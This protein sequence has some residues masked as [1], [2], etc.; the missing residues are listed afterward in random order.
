MDP[1]D[2]MV[3]TIIICFKGNDRSVF[4]F[5]KSINAIAN[6][7]HLDDSKG[8]AVF[9]IKDVSFLWRLKYCKLLT[10]KYAITLES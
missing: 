8:H 7:Y 10:D 5:Q 4:K 2:L 9:G 6:L 1:I 3:V